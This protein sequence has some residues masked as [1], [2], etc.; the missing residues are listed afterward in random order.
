MPREHKSRREVLDAIKSIPSV[1]DLLATHE[2]HF[3]YELDLEVIVYGRNYKGKKVGPYIR[4]LTF[5]PRE[6]IIVEDD[7]GGNTLFVL[8]DGIADVFV[9]Q[10]ERGNVKVAELQPGTQFG[11][12]SVLAGVPRNATV[13][14]STNGSVRVLEIQR[15]ALRLLRKLPRFRENLDK[16]YRA[17]GR[18]SAIVDLKAALGLTDQIADGIKTISTFRVFS[19]NHVLF[20]EG[21]PVD[22]VYLMKEGRLHRVRELNGPRV[23]D[24]LGPGF[25]HGIE[26]ITKNTVWQCTATLMGR[27]EVIEIPVSR[28]R[29]NLGLRETLLGKL[30]TYAPP[31]PGNATSVTQKGRERALASQLRLIETG[32]VDATNLLVMDMD[33]CVRCGNCS[34]ACH[35][36]HG[37]SRLIRRGIHVTR[38][39]RGLA[40]SIQSVLSPEVCLH[41]K[42]PECLTGCPTGAIGRFGDGRI[43]INPPTCIGCG[44]CATQCPYNAISMVPRKPEP[45]VNGAG[46]GAKVRSLLKLGTEPLPKPVD[47]TED[48][49]AVKC[50]LC[51]DRAELNP[52]GAKTHAY[53]CEENCPTGALAR[54]NPR[55]YFDEI[56]QIDGLLLADRTSAVGRNIHRS[57]PL[58]RWL[59]LIG[60]LLTAGLC[61]AA[62]IGLIRYGFDQRLAGFLNMR[63][64]TGLAGLIGILAVM[65][66]PVRRQIYRKRAGPLRYW[67]LAHSY[68]GVIAGIMILLH[69]GTDS[70]GLLTTSLMLA[71][72][73]VIFTG[74]AGIVLYFVAPRM[75]TRI[76]GSPLLLDDLKARRD[77]LRKE[78]ASV[79][80]GAP[81]PLGS[82]VNRRVLPK[83]VSTG[84]LL[85]QYLK[86]E[87]LER[88][89]NQT[90]EKYRW[91]ELTLLRESLRQE[92]LESMLDGATGNLISARLTADQDQRLKTAVSRAKDQQ[93]KFGRAVAAVATL[94]RVDALIYLHRMLK[95]WLPPHIFSTALMLALMLVHIVQVV[96]YMK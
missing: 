27:G 71:Y 16:T 94:R 90:K 9:R 93:Q 42:D 64:I 91:A 47:A 83:L 2:G 77:E 18:N 74:I 61:A 55:E 38:L 23:E 67:M 30:S 65:T 3:D 70:G 1:A 15:P 28:F 84:Y 7:W 45:A 50:N 37:Q 19:K 66:Y 5:D 8:V 21:A 68:L 17:H 48:L 26:G 57:D 96:L 78:I 92:G 24:Y 73:L 43:D 10:G 69:G 54:I 53:S 56:G 20:R 58:R 59:H 29:Q 36:I 62:V 88:L 51:S 46:F 79:I 32:L 6:A 25:C 89:V 33:L 52:E 14:A 85:R 31:L 95:V 22:R 81:E 80:N 41:C 60:V 4:L 86:R 34:L 12:M 39:E 72:D 13:T 76:E 44:D 87:P 82:L 11:E 49:L 75:L 63:W 35:K 40:G